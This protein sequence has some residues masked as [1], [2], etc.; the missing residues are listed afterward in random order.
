MKAQQF[1]ANMGP[2]SVRD[3]VPSFRLSVIEEPSKEELFNFTELQKKELRV[4]LEPLE[5]VKE[6]ITMEGEHHKKSESQRTRDLI[7]IWW[8]ESGDQRDF[9]EFYRKSQ[10][11]IR[12]LIQ[13]K[14]EAA[15]G[16]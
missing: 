6:Q 16:Y 8:R 13:E 10:E 15:K 11:W 2:V 5:G 12:N 1:S 14:I 3:G 9:D 7:Y 4:L